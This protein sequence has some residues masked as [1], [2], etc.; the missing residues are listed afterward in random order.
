M[1]RKSTLALLGC[2]AAAILLVAPP[3]ARA[4]ATEA[5]QWHAYE[6]PEGRFKVGFPGMP[7]VKRGRIRTDIGDVPS[8]RTSAG[9][10][11]DATY[12]VTYYDYPKARI[13]SVP[14]DKLLGAVRDGLVFQSKGRLVADRKFVIGK[15]AGREG[16]IVGADG[17][18]Y[19]IKLMLVENRL[20]QLTAMASPPAAAD[21]KKFFGSFQLTGGPRP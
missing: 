7:V 21:D 9:E 13:A 19:R 12:D 4:Q 20:Y 15:V 1:I 5:T 18:R 14:P 16:E 17:T 3:F 10:G 11:S 6:S 8:T 2:L